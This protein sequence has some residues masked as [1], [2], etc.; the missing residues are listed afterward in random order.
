MLSSY[1]LMLVSG[2][3]RIS[4][5][6]SVKIASNLAS[7]HIKVYLKKKRKKKRESADESLSLFEEESTHKRRGEGDVVNADIN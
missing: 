3:L 1:C 4:V 6:K 7:V 2:I 5:F